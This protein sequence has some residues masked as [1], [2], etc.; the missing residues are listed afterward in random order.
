MRGR[1]GRI[2]YCSGRGNVNCG[3]RGRGL[4]NNYSGMISNTKRGLCN[5]LGISVLNYG[6]KPAAYQT[7]SSWEKLVQYVGTN[8]GQDISNELQNKLTV[9]LVEPV[10]APEV[11]ERHIIQERMIRTGQANIQTAR[12][13]QKI[14]LEAAVTAGIDDAAPTKLAIFENAIAQGEYKSNVN[15]PIVMT[16]SEKTH[17]RNEWC[18]YRERNDQLTNHRGQGFSLILVQCTQLLQDKM[19]K[20]TERNVVSTYYDPLKLYRLN[21]KT[22]LGQTEDQYPFATVY[23][24]ELGFMHS[25]KT[26]SP[27]HSGTSGPIKRWTLDKK[28]A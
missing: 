1:E 8:Y 13:T 11:I 25:G 6:Q 16:D 12:E 19:K 24:Q 10:H 23:N 9:N 17:Y 28:L 26:I 3:G 2:S 7:R 27:N 22:V 15:V 21:E 14:N 4:G 20:E 5:A 18:T